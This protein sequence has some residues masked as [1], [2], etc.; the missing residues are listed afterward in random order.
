MMTLW[1]VKKTKEIKMPDEAKTLLVA[2]SFGKDSVALAMGL[3]DRGIPFKL[4][5]TPTGDELPEMDEHVKR[6]V[7]LTGAE[8]IQPT[9]HTLYD[10]IE[11]FN[12]LPNQRSRWCTRVLKIEPCIAWFR[13]NPGYTLAV[14]L[15]ADEESRKGIYSE[16]IE[17]TFPLQEWGW[18]LKEVQDYLSMKGIEIPVR[19]DCALCV[20]QRQGEWYRLWRYHPEAF[21][22]GIELEEKT[23]HTFRSPTQFKPRKD[24]SMK[25]MTR[26]VDLAKQYA[27][28]ER[29]RG[30]DDEDNLL[31]A[32]RVCRL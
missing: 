29:P 2:C 8:L 5:Y 19:T 15:R 1:T 12:M 16:F 3:K 14:G 4:F 6:I 7:A 18:G 13:A 20:Y 24:G 23:G 9:G 21:Q 31:T 10:W 25:W 28:G 17:T 32:C 26:L 30:L 22:R 27:A 11:K